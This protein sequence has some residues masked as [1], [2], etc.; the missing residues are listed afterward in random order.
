MPLSI[1]ELD[2][3]WLVFVISGHWSDAASPD[4]FHVD[5]VYTIDHNHSWKRLY[6]VIY[7]CDQF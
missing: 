7:D 1:F 3:Y 4:G 6:E 2:V 5:F